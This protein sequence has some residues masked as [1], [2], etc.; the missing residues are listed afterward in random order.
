MLNPH[1]NILCTL[2]NKRFV[3]RKADLIFC[4]P[5][6]EGLEFFV[7]AVLFRFDPLPL[8]ELS[9]ITITKSTCN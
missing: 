4:T 6:V 7:F 5:T 3:C 1:T 8:L 2:A 9:G